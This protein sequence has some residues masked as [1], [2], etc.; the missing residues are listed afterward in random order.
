MPWKPAPALPL[1]RWTVEFA[2]RSYWLAA[3]GAGQFDL[4][5]SWYS[6]QFGDRQ[7]STVTSLGMA[8]GRFPRG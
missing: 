1:R 2:D 4:L 3:Y 8:R 5:K 7:P 6:E